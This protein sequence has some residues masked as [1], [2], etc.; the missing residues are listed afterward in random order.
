MI[1]RRARHFLAMSLS[2]TLGTMLGAPATAHANDVVAAE[3]LFSDAKKLARGEQWKEACPKF[4]ESQRADPAI[5][6]EFNLAECNEHIGKTA[7]A[8]AQYLEVAALAKAAGQTARENAARA[9]AKALEPK[10]SYLTVQVRGNEEGLELTR[11]NVPVGKA[12]RGTPVPID[13]GEH[14]VKARAPGKL[15]WESRVRISSEGA[16]RSFEVVVPKL[17]DDPMA[18]AVFPPPTAPRAAPAAEPPIFVERDT[19]TRFV[20]GAVVAGVGVVGLGLG[21][22]FAL[23][24]KRDHDDGLVHCS[25]TVCTA[26]GVALRNDA[27]RE[28]NISTAAFLGGGA[29]LAGAVMIWLT[30]PSGPS[31]TGVR[32]SPIFGANGTGAGVSGSW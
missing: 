6:T 18:S 1:R 9:R 30:A 10:L 16:V 24:S 31:R 17:E 7:S 2:A 26:E 14:L 15:A 20:V 5:G 12:Q 3:K 22:A 21:T 32:V 27:R 28:G 29:A 19:Q 4:E 13:S 11:D 8:W 25:G 23:M